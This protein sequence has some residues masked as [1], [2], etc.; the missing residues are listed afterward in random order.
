MKPLTVQQEKFCQ[1]FAN[2]GH[3]ARAYRYAYNCRPG[4]KLETQVSEASRLLADER[5]QARIEQIRSAAIVTSGAVLT[6]AEVNQALADAQHADPGETIHVWHGAC[7]WCHGVNHE[8]H[9]RQREFMDALAKAQRAKT[10]LPEYQGGFGYKDFVE[11]HPDCPECGG[12]GEE[13]TDLVDTADMSGPTRRSFLGVKK[14]KD[15]YELKFEDKSK[16]RDQWMKLNGFTE[17]KGLGAELA[18]GMAGAALV[19]IQT[20]TDPHEATRLYTDFLKAKPAPMVD[21]G[22]KSDQPIASEP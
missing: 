15:G 20:V 7:R 8:R 4:T 12:R 6:L 21:G 16:A 9:W 3:G 1:H 19:A 14:T 18:A 13:H 17:A 5:L 10:P 22:V 2:Q 11:P